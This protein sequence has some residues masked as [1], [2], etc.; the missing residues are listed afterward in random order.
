MLAPV[1]VE[2]LTAISRDRSPVLFLTGAGVSAESGIPTFRGE[3]G[4]WRVGSRN[5]APQEMATH[6]MFTRHPDA[7]WQWYLYRRGICR[8]AEP[9]AGH[10]ALVTLEKKIGDRFCLVTQNVDGL[11]QRAGNTD[12]RTYAIHGNIDRMRCAKGCTRT[13]V[14]VPETIE[15][16]DRDEPLT[17]AERDALRCASCGG[18]T[19]PHVLW[20][21]ESYDEEHYKLDSSIAAAERAALLVTA[22]TSGATNLPMHIASLAAGRGI[23]IVDVNPEPNPMSQIATS[24]GGWFCEGKSGDWLP[25]LAEAL[26]SS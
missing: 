12:A 24:R 2:A 9:N 15:A 18:A 7:V 25:L 17:Q 14:P 3:E 26:A 1:L 11:H 21:D 16:K 4:Y 13:P 20:F 8:A 5:Y 6:A 23:P 22:G 10:R 19:R